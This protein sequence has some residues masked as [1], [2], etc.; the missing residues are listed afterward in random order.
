MADRLPRLVI[1]LLVI[2]VICIILKLLISYLF[3][4]SRLFLYI[5]V[6][7]LLILLF[8]FLVKVDK[9]LVKKVLICSTIALVS[10]AFAIMPIDR[11]LEIARFHVSKNYYDSAVRSVLQDISKSKDTVDAQYSL[12]YPYSLLVFDNSNVNYFKC[13]D[14]VAITFM[15]SS[16]LSVVRYYVYFSDQKAKTLFEHPGQIDSQYKD[17]AFCDKIEELDGSHWSY[18][19]TWGD[20]MK[21]ADPNL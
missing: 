14:S 16:S 15:A 19:F 8:I 7:M 1:P 18:V 11:Q 21:P 10:V 17:G 6:L 20:D 2:S 12:K 9:I 13:G 4:L 5:F 3:P